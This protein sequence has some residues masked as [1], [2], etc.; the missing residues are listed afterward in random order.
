MIAPKDFPEKA[1]LGII[2]CAAGRLLDPDVLGKRARRIE[3]AIDYLY[4]AIGLLKKD[5][6]TIE[7]Q[8]D[9]TAVR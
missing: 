2:G 4:D 6:D 1:T 7:S 8:D 9:E 3:S 5:L